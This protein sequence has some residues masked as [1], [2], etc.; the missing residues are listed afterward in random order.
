MS[1]AEAQY[2]VDE[3]LSKF[4]DNT[5]TGLEP[6]PVSLA[7]NEVIGNRF[8]IRWAT[9]DIVLN[10]EMLARLGGMLITYTTDP[11]VSLEKPTQG[12]TLAN[13]TRDELFSHS[14]VAYYFDIPERNTDYKIKAFPYTDHGVFN[15]NSD[16]FEINIGDLNVV[17]GFHQDFTVLDPDESITYIGD[18][19]GFVPVRANVDEGVPTTMGSWGDWW[20]LQQNKPFVVNPSGTAAYQLDENDY[21]K[22]ATGETADLSNDGDGVFVWLP[23]LYHKEEYAE[24]GNSRDVYFC[25]NQIDETWIPLGFEDGDGSTTVYEGIW[26]PMFYCGDMVPESMLTS[27]NKWYYLSRTNLYNFQVSRPGT[28]PID[29]YTMT[30]EGL[31]QAKR[32]IVHSSLTE[33]AYDWSRIYTALNITNLTPFVN[34][35]ILNFIRDLLYM[36]GKSTNVQK[37]FGYGLSGYWSIG[38]FSYSTNN[39]SYTAGDTIS[40]Y[41]FREKNLNLPVRPG[42][43]IANAPNTPG[44]Y[45]SGLGTGKANKVF[46]SNALGS[47]LAPFLTA[48]L[49][50][51]GNYGGV[52]TNNNDYF[53]VNAES[54]IYT[55]GYR[56]CKELN[57][58]ALVPNWVMQSKNTSNQVYARYPYPVYNGW[59]QKM[60]LIDPHF[61][62][63]MS[64]DDMTLVTDDSNKVTS[65]DET[66]P[67]ASSATGLTD[68]GYFTTDS[69]STS[70]TN[71]PQKLVEGWVV[72]RYS[73]SY[74]YYSTNSSNRGRI[75]NV[76]ISSG[77][78][79][80]PSSLVTMSTNP[81]NTSLNGS[82]LV[83]SASFTEKNT[84]QTFTGIRVNVLNDHPVAG[85]AMVHLPST[86]SYT[87]FNE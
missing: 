12:L 16:I 61:G 35:S 85:W 82:E 75:S 87:P 39:E 59:G 11:E 24:D 28:Y 53:K 40:T 50:I 46:H 52:T 5:Q 44:F 66:T 79:N 67:S 2:A 57:S 41:A 83:R 29:N 20:W 81:E 73:Y 63:V 25:K 62:S 38:M 58:N 14:A 45:G 70:Y 34:F 86:T 54:F 69:G 3:I 55:L 15:Y 9:E 65:I 43:V 36:L 13:V 32:D 22:K 21:T 37:H 72:P 18:C 4:N 78:Q 30:S 27:A 76:D 17:Y 84:Y 26:F 68:V 51:K 47:Y 7:V 19:E 48:C 31:K 10:N 49:R 64:F 71:G 60:V 23:R 33:S 56:N 42:Q 80:G 8:A 1:Y 77:Y 6:Y 74:R